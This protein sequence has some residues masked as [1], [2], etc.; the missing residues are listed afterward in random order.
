MIFHE[1]DLKG[2]CVLEIEKLEDHRG[3][4]ARAWCQKEFEEHH[5]VSRVRQANVVNAVVV[6]AKCIMLSVTI[7][8]G[9][10]RKYIRVPDICKTKKSR[11]TPGSF[12]HHVQI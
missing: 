6:R 3:F 10:N 12:R 1:T 8:S 9:M 11:N 7:A 5:L 4:F 2:A